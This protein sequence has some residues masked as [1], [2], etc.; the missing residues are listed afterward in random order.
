[1]FRSK[2]SRHTVTQMFNRIAPSYDCINRLLTFGLD[3]VWRKKIK[4]FVPKV[5]NLLFVDLATGTGDQIFA[6]AKLSQIRQFMGFDLSEKMLLIGQ[7]KIIQKNLKDRV[8]LSLG[9]AL[10]IPLEENSADCMSISFGI[11]NTEDPLKCL[12]EMKR[13]LK[14]NGRAFILEFSLPRNKFLNFFYQ[15]HLQ[16]ILPK[17]GKFLSK[18]QMAYS[19]LGETIQSFPSGETFIALMKQAGFVNIRQV[20]MTFGIV[21]LYMGDKECK[22]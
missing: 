13:C 19:Y 18:D 9:N 8:T 12:R 14:P 15:L 6:L 16:H 17:I 22:M 7:N 1:M 10:S 5:E 2:H 3:K 4:R 20:R 11:R 21:T